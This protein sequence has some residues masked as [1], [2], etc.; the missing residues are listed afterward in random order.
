MLLAKKKNKFPP[1]LFKRLKGEYNLDKVRSVQWGRDNEKTAIKQF[2]E[3]NGLKVTATGIW[4]HTS[5][6]L[7]ASPDGL[8]LDENAVVEVKCPYSYRNSASLKET[9]NVDKTYVVFVDDN[10]QFVWNT[11]HEYYH[12][13]QGQMYLTGAEKCY[14]IIWV[15]SGSIACLAMKEPSWEPNIGI[16]RDFYIN[17]Y[18]KE[19]Q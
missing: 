1:S 5:G 17:K 12:Q 16:L 3:E 8:V 6:L 4:L 14:L 15:P 11:E 18:L 10:G 9:L 13:I 2:E 7:A 19:I